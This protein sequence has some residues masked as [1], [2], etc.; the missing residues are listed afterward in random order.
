MFALDLGASLLN[1]YDLYLVD[2]QKQVLLE[3]NK[4]LNFAISD[5]MVEPKYFNT[6]DMSDLLNV[7]LSGEST[8]GNNDIVKLGLAVYNKYAQP[9]EIINKSE[10]DGVPDTRIIT[11]PILP[12]KYKKK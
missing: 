12:M 8:Q 6:E 1:S 2:K 7:I 4:I 5:G 11:T 3:A 10:L 9:K